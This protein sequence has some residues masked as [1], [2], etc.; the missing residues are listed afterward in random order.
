DGEYRLFKGY[1]VQHNNILGPYKGGMRYHPHVDID[2]VKALAT[3]MTFKCALANIPLG[4]GK[5]GVQFDPKECSQ[6]ELM[7]LTRRFTHALGN[8]IGPEYD[9]P[10]PDV[11]TNAQIM[12]WMMDT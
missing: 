3:W 2:E 4:G 12:V 11:N 10:A 6:D 7:R 8:N 9:I 1:R 5:G